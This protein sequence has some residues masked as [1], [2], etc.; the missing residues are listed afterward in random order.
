VIGGFI[1]DFGV[2]LE[3]ED[4][5]RVAVGGRPGVRWTERPVAFV[6]PRPGAESTAARLRAHLQTRVPGWS[7]PDDWVLAAT[8]PITTLRKVDKQAL[9]GQAEALGQATSRREANA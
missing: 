6:V 3:P 2:N 7:I 4:V 9:R 5:A 8:L 1:D